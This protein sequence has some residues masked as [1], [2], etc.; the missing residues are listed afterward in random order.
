V[1]PIQ[2]RRNECLGSVWIQ[3]I[4][5]ER[6]RVFETIEF[7]DGVLR[8]L[9]SLRFQQSVAFTR[10]IASVLEEFAPQL[11]P[12]RIKPG[13]VGFVESIQPFVDEVEWLR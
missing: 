6:Q 11:Q 8:K 4:L 7:V 10:V 2:E 3:Q 13:I 1:A 9:T 12:E 5:L